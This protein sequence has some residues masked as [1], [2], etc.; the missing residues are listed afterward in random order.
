M[1]SP[2]SCEAGIRITTDPGDCKGNVGGY[3]LSRGE[4]LNFRMEKPQS[5]GKLGVK[6]WKVVYTFDA[7]E[8]GLQTA[9]QK[10]RGRTRA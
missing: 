6:A 2:W 8:K 5:S 9:K 3:I 1:K 4:E 7:L 10:L